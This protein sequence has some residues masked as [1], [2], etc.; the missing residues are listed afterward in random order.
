MLFVKF[1]PR[2]FQ[3][4]KILESC[5]IKKQIGIDKTLKIYY[6]NQQRCIW[7]RLKLYFMFF[8]TVN[9]GKKVLTVMV[10][11]WQSQQPI[12]YLKSLNIKKNMTLHRKSKSQNVVILFNENKDINLTVIQSWQ[13][14]PYL[15][16]EWCNKTLAIISIMHKKRYSLFN[17]MTT[18]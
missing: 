5:D 7:T 16:M 9:N 8:L 10:Q 18:G 4:Y 11:Y 17:K 12:Y 6:T 3:Y 13:Q 2:N 14:R 1:S 15:V